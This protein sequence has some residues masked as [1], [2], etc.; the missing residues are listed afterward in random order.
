MNNLPFKRNSALA[1]F[2]FFSIFILNSC[3]LLSPLGLGKKKEVVADSTKKDSALV[4]DKF[5]KNAKINSGIFNV[6]NKEKDFFFEIPVEK[7]DKDFLLINKISSVPLALNEAGLNKGMNYENKVIRFSLKKARKEIWASEIKPQVEVPKEDAIARS[8][9]DNFTAS[10][11]ESFKIEGYN[12]DSSSVIIKI[13]K[14]FDGTEKSF[15][16]VFT[17]IGLGTSP[18]TALSLIDQMKSFDNNIV[19]RSILSTRVTE[20]NE[21]IPISL[22]ITSNILE[23]PK[24]AMKPRFS[25]PRVGYFTTPRWYFSDKQQEMEKRELVTRWR[26][27][28]REEDV[29]RYLA[30]ELVVPKKPIVFYIDPATPQQWRKQIIEGVHDWQKAFEEAGFKDAII[31]K[32]VPKGMD[33]DIDDANTSAITYA[34][35]PQANAMGP[36]VVDPRTGEILE[37]DVIWWH[38]V[39]TALNTWMRVQTGTIDPTVRGNVF[40]DEKMAHA[41]RFVSSHEIGHTLGLKHNMGSSFSFPVDSLRSASFTQKMGGTA[42]SIMDYARFNY[43]AQPEDQ[44]QAITPVIGLYDKYA[45]AWAYRWYPNK[46]AW[47]ELPL[48]KKEIESK[49]DNPYYWY[50]EQQDPKNTIDPR[51]Q[52]EDLGD[53]AM[54][55][56]TYGLKNLKRIMPQII[57]WTTTSGQ[58]YYKAGKLYMAVIGQW[59]AYADHVSNN[60]GGIYLNNPVLGDGKDAYAPVPRQKQVEALAYLKEHVFT[61]PEWLFRKELMTK[62]F[63]LKDSPVGSFEY[64]PYTL[65]REFQYSLLYNLLQDQRLLRMTEMELLFGRAQAWS[66]EEFL[67]TLRQEIFAKTLKKQNLDIDARMLQQNY[68]DI[69]LVT[70]NKSMDKLNTKKLSFVDQ[71]MRAAKP[72]FCPVHGTTHAT[73]AEHDLRNVHVSGMSR[74]SEMLTVKRAELIQIQKLLKTAQSTGDFTTLAHYQDLLMRINSSLNVNN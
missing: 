33:F 45:I 37:A 2:G 42:T 4:Y 10:F 8:V 28:P 48:L 41:I 66:V 13:N 59:Y 12:K 31:A 53:N 67:K 30:G 43:V 15:N 36:S 17:N 47:E 39:M 18:K 40:S 24:N 54:L 73:S 7:L 70:N 38:N 56:G 9:A 35:S 61:L 46:T 29:E 64:A 62:T 44:V 51:S 11:I 27:E 60:I 58:D 55:A 14:V 68:I 72:A 69:L 21:S 71:F 6:I 50:G 19:V 26:L 16:D 23:L 57:N 3:Q 52:S 25:D 63:P 34:A 32:E 20:G 22:T 74:T 1:S 65:K 49:Q 5:L